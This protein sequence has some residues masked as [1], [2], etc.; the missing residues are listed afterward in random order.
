MTPTAE[1]VADALTVA[2]MGGDLPRLAEVCL[3]RAGD[4]EGISRQRLLDAG[5]ALAWTARLIAALDTLEPG[6]GHGHADR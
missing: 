4:A 3:A 5:A 1:E 2:G 6:A